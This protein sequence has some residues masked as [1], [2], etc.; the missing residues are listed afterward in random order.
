MPQY[1]RMAD[2]TYLNSVYLLIFKD[3]QASNKS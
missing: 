3:L 2:K 1:F